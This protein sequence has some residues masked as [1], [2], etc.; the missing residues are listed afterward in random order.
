MATKDNGMGPGK[1]PANAAVKSA[2]GKMTG[3][4]GRG[5]STLATAAATKS[6]AKTVSKTPKMGER[7]NYIERQVT[8]IAK[9]GDTTYTTYPKKDGMQTTRIDVM[10]RTKKK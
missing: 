6:A 1:K 9:K 5:V 7:G 4:L 3:A 8:T 10:Q 2:V